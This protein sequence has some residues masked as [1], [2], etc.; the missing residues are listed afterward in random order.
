MT[1]MTSKERRSCV[2]GN[3]SFAVRYTIVNPK[4][5]EELKRYD[6]SIVSSTKAIIIDTS[7]QDIGLTENY[8]IVNFLLQ[9]DEKLNQIVAMLSKDR[10]CEGLLN[11]AVGENISGAGMNMLVDKF[12]E[13]GT[14]IRAEF[15]P[16]RFPLV[17]INAFGEV[18]QATEVDENG[19]SMYRLGI[20]FL[21]LSSSDRE[22][23]ISCV[24]QK[25]REAIRKRKAS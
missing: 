14:I 10:E 21:N 13:A 5:Y 24:F 8:L 6:S 23:I 4:E 7:K 20:K 12:I 16:S 18:I 17:F 1:D 25:Q 15:I 9:M 19:K 22:R 11:K 2:R 3:F